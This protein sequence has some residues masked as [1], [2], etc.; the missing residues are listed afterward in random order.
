MAPVQ[1]EYVVE[2]ELNRRVYN[3]SYT[4]TCRCAIIPGE[5]HITVERAIRMY[6]QL[7]V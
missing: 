1:E 4:C 6:V 5:Q 2:E 3:T 7:L